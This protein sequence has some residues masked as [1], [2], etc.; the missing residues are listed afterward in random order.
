MILNKQRAFSLNLINRVLL[1][2][3]LG[4]TSS[5]IQFTSGAGVVEA[6]QVVTRLGFR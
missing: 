6:C 3:C 2:L 4:R 5:K 1:L